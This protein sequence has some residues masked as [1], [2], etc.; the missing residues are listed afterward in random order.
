M[1][2]I[3]RQHELTFFFLLFHLLLFFANQVSSQGNGFVYTK[4]RGIYS[5]NGEKILL[6]G[7]NLG[8]WL[9][10]EG[11]MFKFKNANSPRLIE[12]VFNE[13]IGPEETKA[14]FKT[15]RDNYITKEDIEFI[16]KAGFNSI[17]VPFNSRL[18]AEES[19]PDYFIPTGFEMLDRVI[20]WC[21]EFGIYVILDMHGAPCGQTGDNIDDSWGYP[22]L[23][24]SPECQKLTINI[25]G[26]IAER[27]KEKNIVAGYDLLNEPIAHY[28]DASKLNPLLEPLYKKIV[29]TIRE[30]DANH[31]IF[32]G[33]A[34]WNTNFSVFGPPFD[35]NLVYTFHKY[36]C[37]TTQE[38]IQEY[39]DFREKYN[40]PIWMGES[41]ENTNEWINSFRQLLGRN[42]IGWCFWPYKKLDAASCVA[43]IN[44]TSEFDSIIV[45]ADKPRTTFQEIRGART[46]EEIIKKALHDYL[47]NMKFRNCVINKEYLKSL[48][49]E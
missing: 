30:V 41:G 37:D 48:G 45:Y 46:S 3:S 18:F 24:E 14:F 40:V 20:S 33:G 9:L 43:S 28:F 34:Q 36:W 12:K 44:K 47:E 19:F 42:K 35:S 23:F 39:I 26:K 1:L 2:I 25:W 6:K 7:I 22:F 38:V 17:R 8:N 16:K 31:I 11:Y 32:L 10:P 13:L 5:S 49:L 4:G 29:K 21:E 15:F 27:Y